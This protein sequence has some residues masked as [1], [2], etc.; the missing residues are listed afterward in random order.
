M[1]I[2]NVAIILLMLVLTVPATIHAYTLE[3]LAAETA[4]AGLCHDAD[5]DADHGST[6]DHQSD[7]RC[8]ELD[9]PYLLPSSLGLVTPTVTGT[10]SSPFYCRQLDG[11][12]RRIYKPPRQSGCC[13]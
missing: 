7:I 12:A 11:Y 10:L 1:T 2:R 13:S 9:S 3:M 4:H 5:S 8:C 6:G